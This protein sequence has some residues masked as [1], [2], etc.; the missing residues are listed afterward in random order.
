MPPSKS[1]WKELSSVPLLGTAVSRTGQ[2]QDPANT[3][4]GSFFFCAAGS[5]TWI[6][7]K[8]ETFRLR[9]KKTKKKDMMSPTQNRTRVPRDPPPRE[10]PPA[11]RDAQ[12]FL[13]EKLTRSA[14]R[15]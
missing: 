13:D 4:S 11:R 2:R 3:G 14:R 12:D 5:R 1:K 15:P 8:S 10:T 7:V 9:P 6:L